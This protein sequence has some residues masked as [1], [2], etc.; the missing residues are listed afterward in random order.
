MVENP[1]KLDTEKNSMPV[2]KT[3]IGVI[4]AAVNHPNLLTILEP[5]ITNKMVNMP[6]ILR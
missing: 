2:I 1:S 3:I 5:R 4:L 6:V